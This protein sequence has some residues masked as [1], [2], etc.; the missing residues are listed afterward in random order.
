MEWVA[1]A[2][3]HGRVGAV[4]EY[5]AK[6]HLGS[7]HTTLNNHASTRP[8]MY[9]G[10]L[11]PAVS[12]CKT[13]EH[14]APG[15][16]SAAAPGS[17]SA[18]WRCSL[19]LPNSFTPTDGRRLQTE[20]YA[21]TKD[22]ASELACRRAVAL[23]LMMEPS[24]VI[25]RPA[26]WRI[27][28]SA[29]LEG[30]PFTHTVHQALP[31]HVAPRSLQA[32]V[33]AGRLTAAEVNDRVA[34]LLRW[35]LTAHGGS[36]DPSRISRAALRQQLGEEAVYS[37]L[38][39]LLLPGGLRPFV[40][41][42]PEFSWTTHGQKGM[43]ITWALGAEPAVAS[44][45]EQPAP[46]SASAAASGRLALLNEPWPEP[47][48]SA[49]P[50][51]ASPPPGSAAP[52]PGIASA[53]ATSGQPSSSARPSAASPPP[54]PATP[55]PGPASAPDFEEYIAQVCREY[56]DIYERAKAN[57][58]NRNPFGGDAITAAASSENATPSL[59]HSGIASG[60]AVPAAPPSSASAADGAPSAPDAEDVWCGDDE[61]VV[62]TRW[63]RR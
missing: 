31:V 12:Q 25:L 42:H 10:P 33:E 21:T 61:E 58:L 8:K 3:R 37:Q 29:L 59:P 18:A 11:V 24:Q 2:Q 26:H 53:P 23:L 5:L 22:E 54:G 36:F 63:D 44:G 57:A 62:E 15:S 40:E 45:Q 41:S 30:L 38:N 35:C 48:T 20:G 13:F 16:A 14:I 9:G 19:D 50:P 52:A 7:W 46:S 4:E 51:A 28:P 34:A 32:G 60:S 17:A 43:L 1:T 39:K 49:G 27:S 56:P 47:S 6:H 55:A